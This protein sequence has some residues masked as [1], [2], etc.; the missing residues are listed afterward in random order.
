MDE[1]VA[2]QNKHYER[3]MQVFEKYMMLEQSVIEE[4]RKRS[5]SITEKTAKY[6]KKLKEK[7]PIENSGI[8]DSIAEEPKSSR[9]Q[10][11]TN[12]SFQP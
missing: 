6:Y 9:K 4:E 7:Q 10:K 3:K 12:F 11:P 1:F 8:K 5:K 2:D